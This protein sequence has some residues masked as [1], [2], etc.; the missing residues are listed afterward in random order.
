RRD[1]GG[2]LSRGIAADDFHEPRDGFEIVGVAEAVGDHGRGILHADAR[3]ALQHGFAG[4]VDV[5]EPLDVA[6]C[7]GRGDEC[8]RDLVVFAPRH[9][10]G[11]IELNV[12]GVLCLYSTA[13]TATAAGCIRSGT[14][15]TT[16]QLRQDLIRTA[17]TE[18]V[19]Q[20]NRKV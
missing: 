9:A 17:G 12:I 18:H 10:T 15:A 13:A 2:G 19:H 11:E 7:I 16:G 14:T 4:R 3:N 6:G 5:D 20:H 8:F 1:V